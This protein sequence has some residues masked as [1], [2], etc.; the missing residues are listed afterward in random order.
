[1]ANVK[2]ESI[3]KKRKEILDNFILELKKRYF[4]NY[5][6]LDELNY[7][8]VLELLSEKLEVYPEDV[9]NIVD[10]AILRGDLQEIRILSLGNKFVNEINKSKITNNKEIEGDLKNVFGE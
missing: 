1:M 10:L 6:K 5:P 2:Y 4:T 8:K 9:K 3:K 7:N